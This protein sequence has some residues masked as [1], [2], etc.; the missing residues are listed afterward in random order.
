MIPKLYDADVL[1]RKPSRCVNGRSWETRSW[2]KR[3]WVLFYNNPIILPYA[4]AL[5]VII[6]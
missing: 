2:M 6:Q 5:P 3:A 4:I 1:M